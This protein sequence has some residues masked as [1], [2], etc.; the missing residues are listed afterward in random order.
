ML[1]SSIADF[2]QP[3]NWNL[4]YISFNLMAR[5]MKNNMV[6]EPQFSFGTLK[7][8]IMYFKLTGKND[9]VGGEKS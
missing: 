7:Y 2:L 6:Q 3:W 8:I 1:I 4:C 9:F 5:R